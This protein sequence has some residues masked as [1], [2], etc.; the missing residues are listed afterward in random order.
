MFT[1]LI[2][3]L[4]LDENRPDITDTFLRFLAG[5]AKEAEA[6]YVLGDFFESWIGDDNLTPFNR[7]IISALKK[8]TAMGLPIF[9]MHGNR[10]FLLGKS[11][12]AQTGCQL[13]PDEYVLNLY[14]TPALLMHGD[15]LCVEDIA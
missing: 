2:S 1:L 14:G 11:F 10:D 7:L 5:D 9:L 3:D 6:L 15:T 13:L 8:A 4:H 12:L